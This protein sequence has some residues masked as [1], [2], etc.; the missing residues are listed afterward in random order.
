MRKEKALCTE[1]I[2]EKCIYE[3]M[4]SNISISHIFSMFK[5]HPVLPNQDTKGQGH[6]TLF[7]H[8]TRAS[9]NGFL[10]HLVSAILF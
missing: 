4:L 2:C 6:S 1:G 10:A 8:F 9:S 7:P 3:L 5:E